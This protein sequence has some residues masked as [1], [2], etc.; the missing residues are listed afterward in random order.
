MNGCEIINCTDYK[1]GKCHNEEDFVNK[2]TGEDMCPR[3]SDA[4]SREEYDAGYK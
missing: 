2:Y 1:D 4:I 3:S